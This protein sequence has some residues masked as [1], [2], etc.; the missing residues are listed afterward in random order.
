M[1]GISGFVLSKSERPEKAIIEK[2]TDLLKSRGPDAGAVWIRENVALGHRRL[3]IIDLSDNANQPM[4]N[5]T[6]DVVLVFN[7][8][9]YNFIALREELKS[10]GCQ[11]RTGS[12]TEV[13]LQAYEKWGTLS[14]KKFNGM[15]A[16]AIAD[17]RSSTPQLFI[18][19]D[20]WGIK[21]IYYS[22][23]NDRLAF[24]STPKS[25]LELPWI[26]KSIS[27]EALAHYL[28]FAHFPQDESIYQDI[29]Q[30][31]PGT[32]FHWEKGAMQLHRY[33][34][35]SEII[36]PSEISNSENIDSIFFNAIE[37]Q[38]VSDTE[39]GCFLSG[40]VDSSLLV[41]YASKINPRLKT[42]S[43]GYAE[44]AFDETPHAEQVAKN[45]GTNHFSFKAS[46][47]DLKKR[48]HDLPLHFDQPH[49]D[50]TILPTLFLADYTSR[51][52]KVVLSGDGGDELFCGYPHQAALIKLKSFAHAPH[53]IRKALTPSFIG[54]ASTLMSF[55]NKAEWMANFI[56]ILGPLPPE[57][58]GSLM[59]QKNS[60]QGIV[61]KL[62]IEKEMQKLSWPQQVEQIY[63]RTF[64]PDTV[65]LKMDRASMAYGLEARVPFLDDEI[66][67]FAGS[68][69]LKYKLKGLKS[70]VILRDLL[71]N[72][73][74][75]NLHL[76][77][78]QG[79]SIPLKDWYRGDWKNWLENTLSKER[80]QRD[81]IFNGDEITKLIREH[82]SGKLNHSHL[83]WCLMSFQLWYENQ[84]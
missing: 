16:F 25:L 26:S 11:F 83:L 65:L 24:A 84:K 28:R 27:S 59:L 82:Q 46:S 10:L 36:H 33:F 37:R 4:K 75:G 34:H 50:P 15:F 21:P 68:L 3:K 47:A 29:H 6:E 63:L 60:Y 78:K 5:K 44:T 8:E 35:P 20:R 22:W 48:V 69:E 61:E 58:L 51:E 67:Q 66:T 42:F 73:L 43:L 31:L 72:K 1:C 56:G 41:S 49:G 62:L 55:N 74:P 17:F 30:V 39:V 80:L 32:Y 70:K 45:F 14:F 2:M 71:K 7:G 54:K 77:K 12:D 53:F 19:R 23:K 64:L 9:I 18:V 76:R 57:K 13:L 40:G 52:V 79:F 38:M 81:G